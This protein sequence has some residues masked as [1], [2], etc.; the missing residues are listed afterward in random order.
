M[1]ANDRIRVDTT[2]LRQAADRMDEVGNKT[3]DIIDTLKTTVHAQNFPWGHDEYGDKFT[4]GDKG[5]TK[6]EENLLTG[7]DNMVGSTGK[8]SKG[9]RDA[10]DKMDNMDKRTT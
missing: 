8:F 10:A 3:K 6:S 4:K 2:K 1:A 5:Y 7:G 9:M